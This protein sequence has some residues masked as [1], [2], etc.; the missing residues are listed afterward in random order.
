[1]HGIGGNVVE[2]RERLHRML[3]ENLY[4]NRILNNSHRGDFVEMMVLDA[5]GPEWRHVGLGW[6]LWDLQRGTG[7]ARAR[8]QVKQ[9]AARQ[10]WGK[11]KRMSFQFPWSD[12]A[13][14][15]VRR[16]FPN[17]ALE[18]DGWFR[19]LFVVGVHD[20]EDEKLCDQTDPSQWRF[21]IVPS[22][23]LKRGQN[24][25][26]LSKATKQW[27]LVSLAELKPRVEIKLS[28]LRQVRNRFLATCSRPGKS[29]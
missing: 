27:P 24:S 4:S 5:L 11:T 22:S 9:C 12:H 23:E 13:P 1:M 6:N 16:D 14:A 8:I 3:I 19:E 17:E 7:A 21:M 26:T 2:A 18:E 20:V 28:E 10:L 29:D 15:Y 25:M